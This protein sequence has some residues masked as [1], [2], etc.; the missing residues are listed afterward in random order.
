[1][2]P[3]PFCRRVRGH[4]DPDKLSPS[5]PDNDLRPSGYEPDELNPGCSTPLKTKT[6][7]KNFS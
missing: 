6:K 5:Q 4:I 7:S 1:L 3:D 2:L